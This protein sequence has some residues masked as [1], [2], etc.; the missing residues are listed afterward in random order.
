MTL[1][2]ISLVTICTVFVIKFAM[3]YYELSE[4]RKVCPQVRSTKKRAKVYYTKKDAPIFWEID[5][6]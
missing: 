4:L 6:N 1:L 3:V 2:R 5:T